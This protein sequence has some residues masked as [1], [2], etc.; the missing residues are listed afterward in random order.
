MTIAEF[1]AYCDLPENADRN[2]ELHA[3]KVVEMSRPTTRH[4][5]IQSKLNSRL[6]RDADSR[7][8]AIVVTE[9]TVVIDE[10]EETVLG[11]DVAYWDRPFDTTRRWPDRPPLIAVEVRSPSESM[12]KVLDKVDQYLAAG[13]AYV[14]VVDGDE[15]F[16]TV[17]T[18]DRAPKTY[19]RGDTLTCPAL[20]G[21]ALPLTEIFP[22]GPAS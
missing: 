4:G 9:A 2:L 22:D 15:Q 19:D 11:P 12:P 21:F 1:M 7:P 3:G 18:A 20:E 13:V 8:G 6:D 16:V 14:W 5:R 17:Y 10:V